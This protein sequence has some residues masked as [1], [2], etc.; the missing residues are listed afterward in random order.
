MGFFASAYIVE[1]TRNAH[2]VE[3]ITSVYST[4]ERRVLFSWT[5]GERPRGMHS[6]ASG[7]LF[8]SEKLRLLPGFPRKE[9]LGNGPLESIDQCLIDAEF[10]P[11]A[12]E[13]VLF[14]FVLPERFVPRP[15]LQPLELPAD[16]S[17]LREGDR[18]VIT[19]PT[20][21]GTGARRRVR[22][23]IARIENDETLADFDLRHI[24]SPREHKA[25]RIGAELNLGIFKLTFGG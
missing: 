12:A 5:S 18:L 19:V 6:Y 24:L 17:I 16:P 21:G 10:T 9:S 3:L 22:F 13:P 23:W 2:G 8:S 25:P 4:H 15:S 1:A 11:L 7:T 14:H 20:D